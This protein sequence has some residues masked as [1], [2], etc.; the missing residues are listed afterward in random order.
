MNR[1]SRII[2]GATLSATMLFGAKVPGLPEKFTFSVNPF[3]GGTAWY[4]DASQARLYREGGKPMCSYLGD[5]D[6]PARYDERMDAYYCPGVTVRH[7]HSVM[8]DR[9]E[10]KCLGF[11]CGYDIAVPGGGPMLTTDHVAY[12]PDIIVTVAQYGRMDVVAAKTFRSSE[13]ASPYFR[14][15]ALI[16]FALVKQKELVDRCGGD[17]YRRQLNYWI[18]TAEGPGSEHHTEV[19][20]YAG[21]DGF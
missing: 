6:F 11:V 15:G 13:D 3:R 19:E 5:L 7:I 8:I 2:F 4:L 12:C 20:E 10:G 1:A 14:N 18:G 21:W 16:D 9:M 17:R